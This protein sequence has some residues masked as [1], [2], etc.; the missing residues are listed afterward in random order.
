MRR[1]ILLV[2]VGIVSAIAIYII[3]HTYAYITPPRLIYIPDS[4]SPSEL[5]TELSAQGV[6]LNILDYRLL[7]RHLK[8]EAGWVRFNADERMTREEF[9]EILSIKPRVQTR[10]IVMYS[11]DNIEEFSIKVARQTRLDSD[12]LIAQYEHYSPYPDGGILAGFYQI[13]YRATS[14]AII[15]YMVRESQRRF[16]QIAKEWLGGYDTEQWLEILTIASIIQKE[17]L[18]P[19]EMPLVSSVIRNRLAQGLRLQMDAS[20]NYGKYSHR[21]ITPERIKKDKS[22]YN[23]YK[24]KGL[25]HSPIGSASSSAILAAIKPTKTNFIYFMLNRNGTHDFSATYAEHLQNI[26]LYR[27]ADANS[28]I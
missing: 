2:T 14:S 7:K 10:R 16:E 19:A 8:P 21:P 1:Q 9:V 26:R 17:T 12:E 11:S 6:P 3:H 25:P 22:R 18:N 15:Y 5:I 28:S 23:T 27:E 13:P 4:S 24:H 20:L